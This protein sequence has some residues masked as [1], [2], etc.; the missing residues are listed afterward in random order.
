MQEKLEAKF[1]EM[2][3]APVP[4]NES[5]DYRRGYID[6]LTWVRDASEEEE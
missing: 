2:D 6:A 4:N 3:R 1:E 5:R